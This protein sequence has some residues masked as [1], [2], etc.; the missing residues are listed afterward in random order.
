MN[1]FYMAINELKNVYTLLNWSVQ[2][3]QVG[4]ITKKMYPWPGKEEEGILI[5]AHQCH[6]IQ[7]PFHHHNYFFFNYT[8]EG[9]YETVSQKYNHILTVYEN[10]LYA[11][12]PWAGHAMCVHDDQ[13]TTIIGV[14]IK[15]DI[16]HRLLLPMITAN[17]KLFRFFTAPMTNE[18]SEEFLHFKVENSGKIR[19]ILEMMVVEY[20][21]PQPDTQ[22]I[23][24]SLA[25]TLLM[26]IARE[27]HRKASADSGLSLAGQLFS[28]I[29]EHT[30]TVSLRSLS[31]VF[32]YHPSYISSLLS[33]EYGKTFSQILLEQRMSRALLLLENTSLTIDRIAE[34]TGYS[35][36][37]NFHKV[38]RKYYGENPRLFMK[39]SRGEA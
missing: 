12:Q 28:Y 6:G 18:Y 5:C 17:S 30:D 8:Y 21:N 37:S 36:K 29:Q 26:L 19:T 33:Q 34:M 16:L 3:T 27:Y 1:D 24:L 32:S 22:N 39:R 9:W 23:L 20:A 11:G 10:E 13:S 14:L 4:N 38:F 2:D 31:A 25:S 15:K 35:D 7:E